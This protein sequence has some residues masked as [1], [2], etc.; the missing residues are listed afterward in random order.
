[1]AKNKKIYLCIVITYDSELKSIENFLGEM[2]MM[3][4]QPA[5]L[6]TPI[7]DFIKIPGKRVRPLLVLLSY[8]LYHTDFQCA[9]PVSSAVECFHN[10][11]LIHDD[12]V[13]SAPTRRGHPTVHITHGTDTAI[14]A[15]DVLMV[16]CYELLANCQNMPFAELVQCF[17]TMSRLVC[18]GQ[19]L[20]LEFSKRESV[21]K[22]EYL[23]M[24]TLKTATLLGAALELGAIAAN[25][26]KEEQLLLKNYGEAIG[27]I[28]QLQDDILD[29][30]ATS[31]ESGKVV[32]GDILE[33]KRTILWVSAWENAMGHH[34]DALRYWEKQPRSAEKIEA[35]R[36]I[37]EETDARGTAQKLMQAYQQ[38]AD[39]YLAQLSHRPTQ[40]LHNLAQL[41]INRQY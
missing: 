14:I 5:A 26:S 25:A 20:D 27:I 17:T 39:Y 18:E 3:S 19:I 9:L 21:T 41:L 23:E 10:F 11:T 7:R 8:Q 13:D 30:Y 32:G 34:Q 33:N 36:A 29:L 16:Y 40:K 38:Q 28:F 35:V 22:N 37:F 2:P 4:R 6:Y 31:A 24:I 12:I 1:M 15:G